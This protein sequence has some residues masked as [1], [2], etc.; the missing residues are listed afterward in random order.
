[1]KFNFQKFN[2]LASTLLVAAMALFVSCED[3]AVEEGA[4]D[5]ALYITASNID[6]TFNSVSFDINAESAVAIAYAC[7]TAD[8]EVMDA[9]RVM[10]A[11]VKQGVNQGS[12]T[13]SS[14]KS[15]TDYKLY[16]V[17]QVPSVGVV[18]P[19]VKSFTT[20]V[21]VG[22]PSSTTSAGLRA[23]DTGSS[24]ATN[25][26][27]AV[28]NGAE[29]DFSLSMVQPT[30]IMENLFYEMA[31]TGVSKEE[32]LQSF[33]TTYGY[34]QAVN[35]GKGRSS[36]FSYTDLYTTTPIIPGADYTIYSLSFS[37]DYA[38]YAE[39]GTDGI[40]MLET[41]EM[42]ISTVE[43]P[44]LGNP[45]VTL[46]TTEC[47]YIHFT[48]KIT[49][50]SDA[51]YWASYFTLKA[52]FDEFIANYDAL[53]GEGQ[54]VK[55]LKE[56]V[57]HA[58]ADY[59][60]DVTTNEPQSGAAEWSTTVSWD[61]DDIEFSRIAVGLDDN[62]VVGD[63]LE[64]TVDKVIPQDN[65]EPADYTVSVSHVGADSFFIRCTLGENCRQVYW[66]LEEKGYFDDYLADEQ[67]S[68][69]LGRLLWDEGYAFHRNYEDPSSYDETTGKY[70]EFTYEEFKFGMTSIAGQS[71]N[72]T[73]DIVAVG[74]NTT[75]GISTPEIIAT[76]TTGSF[77]YTGAFDPYVTITIPQEEVTKTQATAYYEVDD[78]EPFSDEH[79]MKNRE[80][81]HVMLLATDG[82]V[83]YSEADQA[84]Y[85]YTYGNCWPNAYCDGITMSWPALE[86]ATEYVYLYASANENGEVGRVKRI[87]FTTAS[88]DGGENPEF[89]ISVKEEDVIENSTNSSYYGA[90]Y[91]V[92][93][94]ADVR[95]YYHLFY[96]EDVLEDNYVPTDDEEVL[97]EYFKSTITS[98]GLPA[99]D[100]ATNTNSY[101]IPKGKRIWAVADGFGSED[102][103]KMLSY[104]EFMMAADGTVTIGEQVDV[105]Y[106]GES[107]SILS[108]SASTADLTALSRASTAQEVE[109]PAI[110]Y[111]ATPK[112]VY[113]V[114]DNSAETIRKETGLPVYSF[115]EM[116]LRTILQGGE[117][118]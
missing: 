37:G 112:K 69:D 88:N 79:Y 114:S 53:E 20:Q 57:V 43:I 17:A 103:N 48:H 113:Q 29:V 68:E 72:T 80:F 7:V 65:S 111:V 89:K 34:L 109:R 94:T 67:L 31:K 84:K 6:P 56:Y 23:V 15:E 39:G 22:E 5:G 25:L 115:L 96:S 102:T 85:L 90:S 26:T 19:V 12:Y 32:Y 70:D 78:F 77:S 82:V 59:I 86:S 62:L 107:S 104:V 118:K 52:E 44:R 95:G 71:T 116:S 40:V 4:I 106:T 93:P 38:T 18:G 74:L 24:S 83:S 73:F 99:T 30:I 27:W 91:V 76:F 46:E 66:R 61:Q 49:P 50:N 1:M 10:E 108:A 42:P 63:D 55:R 8:G 54:G 14:L 98:Q 41:T 64:Q 110:E 87:D 117:A 35:E 51:K 97:V 100:V 21:N 28:T 9:D 13:I 47:G 81:Y 16:V 36:T 11:G 2:C 105:K 3:A 92:T 75:G 45:S 101:D 33:I 60:I 58:D